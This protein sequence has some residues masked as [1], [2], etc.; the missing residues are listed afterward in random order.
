MKI[1]GRRMKRR[2]ETE[3]LSGKLWIL[4]AVLLQLC[5]FGGWW[6]SVERRGLRLR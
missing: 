4:Y 1:D 6:V 3:K 5:V 2:R